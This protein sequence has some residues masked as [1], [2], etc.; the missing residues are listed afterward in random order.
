MFLEGSLDRIKPKFTQE[1]GRESRRVTEAWHVCE[2][3]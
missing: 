2:P 1:R 3:G